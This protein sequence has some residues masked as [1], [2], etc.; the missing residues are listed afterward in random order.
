MNTSLL[1][2]Q[3]VKV[4]NSKI[5]TPNNEPTIIYTAPSEG[6]YKIKPDTEPLFPGGPV[7]MNK[8]VSKNLKYPKEAV[9]HNAQ[10]LLI[11]RLTIT[12]D[13]TAKFEEFIRKL[14]YGCEEEV[15]RIIRKMPKWTPALLRGQPVESDYVMTVNFRLFQ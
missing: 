4:A 11:A 15:L 10:G 3:E 6:N 14:G 13:G 7:A 8:F 5:E 2:S 1:F 12:K 9:N